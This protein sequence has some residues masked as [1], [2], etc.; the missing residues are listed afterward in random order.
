MSLDPQLLELLV[1]PQD[2]GPL[3]YLESEQKLV[4]DRLHVAYR[5]DDDIP[6]LLVDEA[7]PWPDT[8]S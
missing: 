7:E 1:C 2:K 4:N 8:E 5:I 3:R 6:V